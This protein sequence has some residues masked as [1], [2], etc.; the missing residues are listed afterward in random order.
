MEPKP[1]S[2]AH[3]PHSVIDSA[4]PLPKR[5]FFATCCKDYRIN[6]RGVTIVIAQGVPD[7][8]VQLIV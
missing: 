6:P 4:K 3:G 5:L 1:T 8:P 7:Q 2:F